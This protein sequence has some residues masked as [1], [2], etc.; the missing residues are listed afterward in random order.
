LNL[1][2]AAGAF[3]PAAFCVVLAHIIIDDEQEFVLPELTDLFFL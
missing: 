1:K 3:T 2:N